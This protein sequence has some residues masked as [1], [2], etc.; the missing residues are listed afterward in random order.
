MANENLVLVTKCWNNK[1]GDYGEK[2]FY[3]NPTFPVLGIEPCKL[4]KEGIAVDC[5]KVLYGDGKFTTIL[6]TPKELFDNCQ[7]TG[8]AI[9]IINDIYKEGL[10]IKQFI[11]QIEG[12]DNQLL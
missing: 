5:T 11:K 8:I 2:V 3:F 12:L 7:K 9:C 10:T 6:G 1:D 4:K